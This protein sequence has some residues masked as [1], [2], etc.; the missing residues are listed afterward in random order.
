MLDS[1]EGRER[2][3]SIFKGGLLAGGGTLEALESIPEFKKA[4]A[5]F[6]AGIISV[7]E[8]ELSPIPEAN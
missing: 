7:D 6:E 1:E 2:V 4:L 5:D 8:S 3:K